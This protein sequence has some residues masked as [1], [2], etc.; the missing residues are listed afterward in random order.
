MMILFD[1]VCRDKF[2]I[3]DKIRDVIGDLLGIALVPRD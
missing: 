3:R 2:E 1:I